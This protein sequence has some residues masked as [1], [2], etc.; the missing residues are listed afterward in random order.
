MKGDIGVG[1]A[2]RH[3]ANTKTLGHAFSRQECGHDV[4]KIGAICRM[5]Y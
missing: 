5:C 1:V 3:D 2:R 4:P